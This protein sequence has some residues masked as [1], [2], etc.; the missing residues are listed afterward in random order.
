LSILTT[1]AKIDQRLSPY[2]SQRSNGKY[3]LKD[4]GLKGYP[5]AAMRLFE[6]QEYIKWKSQKDK[7]KYRLPDEAEW[8][9]AARGADKRLYVWGNMANPKFANVSQ[10]EKETLSQ[11]VGKFPFDCSVYGVYD[12][13]G[14]LSEW[15]SDTKI[16]SGQQYSYIKGGRIN[17]SVE[18]SIID[19]GQL[20][21]SDF[22]T[23]E[24]G[25]RLACSVNDE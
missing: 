17:H 8:I 24:I 23:F 11:P 15:T 2:V 16:T 5:L 12:M 21:Q 4:P 6:A 20:W 10:G 3:L 9:K 22:A 19:G 14:N 25:F 7:L 1:L 18:T 13:I